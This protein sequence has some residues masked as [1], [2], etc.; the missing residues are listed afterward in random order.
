MLERSLPT[1]RNEFPA[2]V[3]EAAGPY[4]FIRF[5]LPE[6]IAADRR[7]LMRAGY[8]PVPKNNPGQAIELILNKSEFIL[9][10]NEEEVT[11]ALPLLKLAPSEGTNNW[12]ILRSGDASYLVYQTNSVAAIQAET[13][14]FADE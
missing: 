1:S 3:I 14:P 7:F 13:I 2:D 9:T 12:Q 8:N 6:L 11:F 10:Q 4:Q 5:I